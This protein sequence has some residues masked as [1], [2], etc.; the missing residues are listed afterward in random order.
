MG[1]LRDYSQLTKFRLSS[2]VMVTVAAGYVIADPQITDLPHFIITLA[3]VALV[4]AGVAALN[5]Y[6]EREL[7]RRM[8]RT[9]DRP[10]AAGRMTPAEA[11]VFGGLSILAGLLMLLIWVNVLSMLLTALTAVLYVAVYTPLKTR[12][13]LNTL[14]GAV[15]GAIPPVIG[16]AAATGEVGLPAFVLFAIL[17]V[18]QIPHFW[19]IARLYREDYERGGMRMLGIADAAGRLIAGQIV[20]W[21]L[22]LIA[23][24]LLPVVVGMTGSFYAFTAL[25]LGAMF[26]LTGLINAKLRTRESARLVFFASL[27]YLPVLL[28]GLILDLAR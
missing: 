26:L 18:W 7:D 25:A 20:L 22:V 19:A 14:V 8:E 11:L 21:C 5:Q 10:L 23:I 12:T 24:S 28:G 16:W 3:G 17:Y 13:T 1:R 2:L 6:I 15:T 9:R 4:A 27:V